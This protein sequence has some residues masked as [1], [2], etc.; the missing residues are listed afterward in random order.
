MPGLT[1]VQQL[2]SAVIS[3]RIMGSLTGF[4]PAAVLLSIYAGA[5]VGGIGGMLVALPIMMSIRT[6]FRVFVQHCENN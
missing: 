4:S 3:P 2:D 5:S 1:L 6:V